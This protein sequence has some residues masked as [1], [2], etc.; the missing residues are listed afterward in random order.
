MAELGKLVQVDLRKVWEHEA[1][2]FSSWLVKPE[3]L[4]LLSDQLGID[5]ATTTSLSKIQQLCWETF[6][7]DYPNTFIDQALKIYV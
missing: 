1:R 6:R 3:N 7:K 5:W 4:S 2:D